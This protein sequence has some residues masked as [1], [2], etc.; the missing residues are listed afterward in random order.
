[1][2]WVERNRD[3]IE[4]IRLYVSGFRNVRPPVFEW[5]QGGREPLFPLA[6]ESDRGTA[7]LLAYCALY[8]NIRP[9]KLIRVLAYLW[10]EYDT[11]FFR[12]NKLPFDDL[13]A[14]M[15]RLTDLDD[16]VLWPKVPGILRSA[17]DFFFRHGRLLPWVQAQADGEETVRVLC[18]EIF[19]MGK[20]SAFKSKPR[21]FLWLMTQ[22]PGADPGSFWNDRTLLPLTPGHL[23]FLRE[24]GPLKNR[25][26][27]PWITPEEKIAYCNRFFRMLAPENPWTVYAALDAYLK[28][29]GFSKAPAFPMAATAREGSGPAPERKWLCRDILG[30]C[31]QCALAPVCPGREET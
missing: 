31:L 2:T 16:W 5:F 24:Y 18:E 10:K 22:L 6:P 26:T 20:T 11:D 25:K 3:Q 7:L 1:M 8:Q 12:L 29:N 28:P 17:C 9:E 13:Q 21:Y 27:S 30:G 19:M 15:R 4:K 14:R 23:R